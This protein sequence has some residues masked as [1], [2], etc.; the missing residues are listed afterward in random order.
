M[1]HKLIRPYATAAYS[2]TFIWRNMGPLFA[3][4]VLPEALRFI[5]R[6]LNA[7]E[8]AAHDLPTFLP[9]WIA[10]VIDSLLLT[11]SFVAIVRLASRGERPSIKPRDELW[12][13]I[14]VVAAMLVPAFFLIQ[15]VASSRWLRT[16]LFTAIPG[17]LPADR[18]G[19][20]F[21]SFAFLAYS[22]AVSCLL[23]ALIYPVAGRMADGGNPLAPEFRLFM[24]LNFWR[25][26]ALAALLLAAYFA[27]ERLYS[28]PLKWIVGSTFHIS[29]LRDSTAERLWLIVWQLLI[30][31]VDFL[32]VVLP[33]VAAGL[34]QKGFGRDAAGEPPASQPLPSQ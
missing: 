22:F 3:A 16:L 24:K 20:E 11:V 18:N 4:F 14:L 31:P 10:Y 23:L 30:I 5:V 26:L 32:R 2:L 9:G 25:I 6:L 33:G 27:A 28:M 17:L 15:A 19:I 12:Q 29:E 21:W 1:S 7:L 34:L 13:P 8:G